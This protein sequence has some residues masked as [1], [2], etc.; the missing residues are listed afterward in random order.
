M[1]AYSYLL[2]GEF[3]GRILRRNLPVIRGYRP[4]ST[5]EHTT[6]TYNHAV[7]QTSRAVVNCLNYCSLQLR[8][9]ELRTHYSFMLRPSAFC[10][11]TV[12]LNIDRATS[13]EAW[14]LLS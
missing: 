5:Q 2:S 10:L 14:H 9:Q 7:L 8:I 1:A 3:L 11:N 13:S 6:H 4:L 12:L